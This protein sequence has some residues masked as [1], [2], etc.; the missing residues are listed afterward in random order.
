[1]VEPVNEL[2][3]DCMRGSQGVADIMLNVLDDRM[4]NQGVDPGWDVATNKLICGVLDVLENPDSGP[5]QWTGPPQPP[6]VMGGGN[7]TC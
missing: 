5:V 3:G 7:I 6:Y 4:P 2:S 1:M